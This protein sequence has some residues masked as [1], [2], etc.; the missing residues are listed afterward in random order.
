VADLKFAVLGTGFWSRFQIPAW[1]EAGGVDLVAVYNRTVSKAEAVA[2]EF[3]VSRVYSDPE[4]LLEIE[5][6]DFVD[7]IT[8]VP[9]H[10]PLVLLAAQHRVPVICQKPMAPDY[11][12]AQKMVRACDAAGVPFF[13]HEN[14]RY[15][16]PMRAV[17]GL[18]DEGQVGQP[19]RARIQFV[20][21]FPIFENQPFLKTL[22]QFVLTDVGSHILDLARCLF[23]EPDSLYCQHVRTR[24]DIAGED[25]ATV[26][27]RIG[28]VICNCEMSQ[29]T[30]TEWGRFPEVFVYIEGKLGTLELGP[31]YWVRLTTEAG[32][33]SRRYPPPRYAW[34]DPDYDVVHAS[35]VPLHREFVAALRADQLPET[36]G[37]DNLKTMRLVY[38]AYESAA[39]NQVITFD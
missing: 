1:F 4:V 31:D 36:S 18:L 30:R 14:F 8:E 17:K 26:L 21:G 25:V 34:A 28:D 39:R 6:L 5:D 10:A 29:S 11:A 2:Q 20:H 33:L 13:V 35:M 32:T 37:A 7:I 15:Q 23:G 3:G 16:A 19:F 38:A 24:A 22:E 27:L 9:A 12:T